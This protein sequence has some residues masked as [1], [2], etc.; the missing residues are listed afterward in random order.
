[1]LR[2]PHLS[3]VSSPLR[4]AALSVA[5]QRRS[6]CPR[7]SKCDDERCARCVSTMIKVC[8]NIRE[9]KVCGN[10]LRRQT[11]VRLPPCVSRCQGAARTDM[12][13]PLNSGPQTNAAIHCRM[14]QF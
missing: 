2:T 7:C 12:G 14:E 1:M 10:C 8:G 5:A 6:S 4:R 3:A 13:A 9:S 11:F